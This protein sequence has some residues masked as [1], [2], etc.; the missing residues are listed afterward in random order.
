MAVSYKKLW[1]LLLDKNLK[2]KDL[3]RMAGISEYHIKKLTRDESVTTEVL[4][5]VMSALDCSI[6]EIA[7]FSADNEKQH[8]SNYG[9]ANKL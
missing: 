4:C 3:E 1:H 9:S 2:K 5:K 8:I 6:N 7:E